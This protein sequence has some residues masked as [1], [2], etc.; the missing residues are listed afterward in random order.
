MQEIIDCIL[1]EGYYTG[2]DIF[3]VCIR[4]SNAKNSRVG[5]SGYSPRAL[6]FGKDERVW[7]SCLNHYLEEADDAAIDIAH[8]DPYYSKA[9]QIRK[10]AMKAV[11]ELDHGDH[12]NRA[13]NTRHAQIEI[14]FS[15]VISFSSGAIGV[16]ARL[17][18]AD[19]PALKP[20]GGDR[21][22]F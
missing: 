5:R 6:V 2:S 9:Y 20:V 18:R 1:Q 11:V 14:S 21:G 12:W 7:A 22:T 13:L 4:A 10:A 15:Q 19:E 8:T 17:A 16:V 3:Q